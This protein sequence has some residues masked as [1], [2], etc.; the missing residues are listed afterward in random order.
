MVM[1]GRGMLLLILFLAMIY[2]SAF[3]GE[4]DL[5]SFRSSLFMRQENKQLV[6]EVVK[7]FASPS[8][9]SCSQQCM[10]NAWCTSTNF[11]LSHKQ[12]IKGTCELNK[13]EISLINENTKFQE[14][15]TFSM[16][17]EVICYPLAFHRFTSNN[18]L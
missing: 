8:L 1:D 14:G 5:T 12:D 16:R 11:K 6:G 4:E 3:A 9:L 7:R 17:L 18:S 13:G 2:A 10:R 15:V